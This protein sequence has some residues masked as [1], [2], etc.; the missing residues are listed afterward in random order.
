MSFEAKVIAHSTTQ[1]CKDIITLQLR[2]PRFIHAENKTHRILSSESEDEAFAVTQSTGLMDDRALSRNASSSRAIPVAKLVDMV[3]NNPA[4][5]IH[6]G[7]NKPG[8]SAD[9]EC[10]EL[11]DVPAELADAY[12]HFCGLG[13]AYPTPQRTTREAW[14]RFGAWLSAHI[15]EQFSL[16]GYHK[17][18]AN[19][20]T[21]HSQWISVVVTATEWDNFFE[22][23]D[24]PDAQPEI[25]HLAKLMKEA[26]ENSSARLLQR[27]E[28]HAPYVSVEEQREILAK[29]GWRG[30]IRVSAAR[31]CR[32][33]YLKHDGTHATFEEDMALCDR[34]A[35]SKP[36]HASPFEHQAEPGHGRSHEA[37]G[38]NLVGWIQH[39]KLLELELG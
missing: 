11:I 14:W 3:R 19:R 15:S 13:G 25:R 26:I 1:F 10:H 39:R 36:I 16:A 27:G 5:P 35:A 6:W 30:V 8:M 32:V 9:E 33:S 28:W 31:C 29:H 12:G 34:L 18:I 7:K 23:R 21:E 37:L 4:M 24:H 20:Q 2:Y 22:L 38:G 17:Q